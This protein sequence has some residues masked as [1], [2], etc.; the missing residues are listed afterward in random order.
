MLG[1]GICMTH[2]SRSNVKG[3]RLKNI[4]TEIS[5]PFYWKP[6]HRHAFDFYENNK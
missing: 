2:Q 4:C 3:F 5:D 6:L 1:M